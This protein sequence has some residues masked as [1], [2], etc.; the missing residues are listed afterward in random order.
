MII[1]WIAK[2]V[3]IEYIPHNPT[4]RNQNKGAENLFHVLSCQVAINASS[5]SA[6]GPVVAY[7]GRISYRQVGSM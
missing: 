5:S 2:S 6:P 1:R 4:E 7:D 3:N